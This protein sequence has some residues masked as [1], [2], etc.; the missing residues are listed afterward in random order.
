MGVKR[1]DAAMSETDLAVM[2]HAF[3][4][5]GVVRG[6]VNYYRANTFRGK[7]EGMERAMEGRLAMP[8]L[9]VWGL[10]D[11]A[12]GEE[13]LVGMDK[14]VEEGGLRV[15]TIE[16]A[17]HWVQVDAPKETS[18]LVWRFAVQVRTGGAGE[19][20]EAGKAG[21]GGGGGG[22]EGKTALSNL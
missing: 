15:V 19:G 17:S 6:A 13:L 1:A 21:G 4:Q 22:G 3:S 10:K 5:Q 20:G 18:E 9:V 12:L 14:Y 2:K 8:V 7:E 16:D 11:R